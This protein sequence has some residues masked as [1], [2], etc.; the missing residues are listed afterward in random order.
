[1]LKLREL[2]RKI[3]DDFKMRTKVSLPIPE[4]SEDLLIPI[5]TKSRERRRE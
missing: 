2:L 3:K 5:S 4:R 1:V